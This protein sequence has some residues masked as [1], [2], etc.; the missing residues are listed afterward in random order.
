[1]ASK[2]S[3]TNILDV[4]AMYQAGA[5][6][7]SAKGS[8]KQD[9][10]GQIPSF[11]K[12]IGNYALSFYMKSI[13]LQKSARLSENKLFMELD[14]GTKHLDMVSDKVVGYKT[15]LTEANTILNSA[16]WMLR[17]NSETYKKAEKDKYEAEFA[18]KNLSKQYTNYGDFIQAQTQIAAGNFVLNPG[19]D[20]EK[21]VGI[22][23]GATPLQVFNTSLAAAG[24]LDQ[25]IEPDELGNL[26]VNYELITDWDDPN[27]PDVVETVQDWL[28]KAGDTDGDG[29]L[30]QEELKVFGA[31]AHPGMFDAIT[32]TLAARSAY[33]LASDLPGYDPVK[34]FNRLGVY[35]EDGQPLTKPK[36]I[37][38]DDMI[39]NFAFPNNPYLADTGNNYVMKFLSSGA[40]GEVLTSY[41][42]TISKTGLTKDINDFTPTALADYVFGD[43]IFTLS[44]DQ[45]DAYKAKFGIDV[46]QDLSIGDGLTLKWMF[47][48]DMAFTDMD[49]SGTIDATD[50][51]LQLLGANEI[52]KESILNKSYDRGKIVNLFH[53]QAVE[54][55]NRN[56]KQWDADNPAT[57]SRTNAEKISSDHFHKLYN[58]GTWIDD[59]TMVAGDTFDM[60][61]ITFTYTGTGY[62]FEYL[63]A[64]GIK[65]TRTLSNLRS[66]PEGAP[67]HTRR[68]FPFL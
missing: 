31:D 33:S 38:L 53:D 66:S 55:Y 39:D 37:K 24:L 46:P 21:M 48:N 22:S 56:K 5:A 63:D 26:V 4:A 27:T 42:M 43:K 50:V 14:E 1:M 68:T 28:V 58:V 45:R 65:K 2:R 12:T 34:D 17:P 41:D 9:K 36:T 47:D 15:K 62:N 67:M 29:V 13:D 32:T 7:A 8:T 61:G 10:S 23:G 57:S 25:A 11:L 18:I 6:G 3:N 54:G 19:T 49:N 16:K 60:S 40:D 59:G 30:S 52:T 44:Q 20:K 51:K 35:K 64:Y